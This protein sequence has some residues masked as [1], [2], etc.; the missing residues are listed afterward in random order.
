[1]EYAEIAKWFFYSM[2]S[3]ISGYG[4]YLI[5]Q[6]VASIADLNVKVAIIIE[7]TE[8]HEKRLDRLEDKQ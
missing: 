2:A 7:R 4:V 1:M 6:L 8:N 5:K 3:G